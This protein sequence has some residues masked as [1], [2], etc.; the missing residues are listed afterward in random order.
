MVIQKNIE[1][2]K[3]MNTP[4]VSKTFPNATG[5]ILSL[6]ISGDFSGV[7]HLEGRNNRN[8]DWVSLAGINLSDFSVARNGF[9][10]SGMYE[11]GIVGIRELRG[12]IESTSGNVSMFGQII[13]TEET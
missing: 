13:S 1:F 8:G 3:G 5:D 2:F 6:Q 11:I 7:V 9:T 10:A 12:R 4:T